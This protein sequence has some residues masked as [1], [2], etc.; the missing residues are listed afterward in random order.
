MT[1]IDPDKPRKAFQEGMAR[2][3]RE[4][5]D[6]KENAQNI[7]LTL[8]NIIRAAR[9]V[10]AKDDDISLLE[11][12]RRVAQET[13]DLLKCS[14]EFDDDP[15]QV[16]LKKRLVVHKAAL[17]GAATYAM[18][19]VEGMLVDPSSE[20]LL[21]ASAKQLA[22]AVNR[23]ASAANSAAETS[24]SSRIQEL[25]VKTV[26]LGRSIPIKTQELAAVS[27]SKAA[28]AELGSRSI[29]ASRK[30]IELCAAEEVP[31]EDMRR[32]ERAV[33]AV[34]ASS[35]QLMDAT[36]A[37]KSRAKQ[38]HENLAE[39]LR[40]VGENADAIL[41][42]T[43][44]KTALEQHSSS[45]ADNLA[46]LIAA[47]KNLAK[48]DAETISLLQAAKGVS[49][50]VESLLATTRDAADDTK[51]MGLAREMLKT[52]QS[53]S[54]AVKH[55]LEQEDTTTLPY[56]VTR[57]EARKAAAATAELCSKAREVLPQVEKSRQKELITVTAEAEL[58]CQKMVKAIAVAE[59][60][61]SEV[62]VQEKMAKAVKGYTKT[63]QQ[64]TN[65]SRSCVPA[66]EKTAGKT[67]LNQAVEHT[68]ETVRGLV[69][70]LQAIPDEGAQAFLAVEKSLEKE[71]VKVD[72]AMLN[73][74]VGNLVQNVPRMQAVESLQIALVDLQR[75]MDVMRK[76]ETSALVQTARD[77]VKTFGA[78]V[79]TS[80]EVA[81][82]T[83]D[84]AEKQAVLQK[85]RAMI[86]QVADLLSAA[87]SEVRGV[88]QE[89]DI[90]FLDAAR[91]VSRSLRQLVGTDE[92]EAVRLANRRFLPDINALLKAAKAA[93][94]G[95]SEEANMSLLSAAKTVSA[96][97]KDLMA[98]CREEDLPMNLVSDVKALL[99]S[100]EMQLGEKGT[101]RAQGESTAQAVGAVKD[102]VTDLLEA[103]TNFEEGPEDCDAAA[104]A[105]EKA[106]KGVKKPPAKA[107]KASL[108]TLVTRAEEMAMAANRSVEAASKVPKVAR[109]HPADLAPFV[110]QLVPAAQAV[111]AACN[112]MSEVLPDSAAAGQV[113]ES[114]RF[115]VDCLAQIASSSKTAKCD[116]GADSKMNLAI[117]DLRRYVRELVALTE[118]ATPGLQLLDDA[119][120]SAGEAARFGVDVKAEDAVGGFT[121]L[122]AASDVLGDS[123][124]SILAIASEDPAALGTAAQEA[125]EAAIAVVSAAQNYDAATRAVAVVQRCSYFAQKMRSAPTG[126]E[127]KELAK[128]LNHLVP[129]LVLAMK[130]VS[131]AE[132]STEV[133][134]AIK[135]AYADVKPA[136][137]DLIEA[138]K[139]AAKRENGIALAA[140]AADHMVDVLRAMVT[141]SPD[142]RKADD[143]ISSAKNVAAQTKNAIA[144]SMGVAKRPTDGFVKGQ[145][146]MAGQDVDEAR[147]DLL[148]TARSMA[149]GRA[150][151]EEARKRVAK[152]VGEMETASIAAEIG[153]L[154]V[155]TG[156]TRTQAQESLLA[157]A[158]DMNKNLAGLLESARQKDMREVGAKARPVADTIDLTAATSRELAGTT[159]DAAF[160]VI[161]LTSAKEVGQAALAFLDASLELSEEPNSKTAQKAVLEARSAANDNVARLREALQTSAEGLAHCE[162]AAATIRARKDILNTETGET[163]E[164]LS[165]SAAQAGV[166]AA[167][168]AVGKAVQKVQR[169][170]RGNAPE[171]G[172][173][174]L[175]LSS[176]VE[177][178]VRAVSA[179]SESV[180]EADL[181]QR[182]VADAARTCDETARLCDVARAIASDP[183]ENHVT[184]LSLAFKSCTD[185]LGGAV[186][187]IRDAAVGDKECR[188]TAVTI[189]KLQAEID[190][191]VIFAEMSHFQFGEGAELS[192]LTAVFE[193][194]AK[195]VL[196]KA[197]S[198]VVAVASQ[199]ELAAAAKALRASLEQLVHDGKSVASAI[200]DFVEFAIQ[201]QVF[202][203]TK[204]A[205]L[206]AQAVVMA[207][208]QNRDADE[209]AGLT[210]T[211]GQ[212]LVALVKQVKEASGAASQTQTAIAKAREV[213]VS[214]RD[215]FDALRP[216]KVEVKDVSD[217]LRAVSQAASQ[218][219]AAAGKN[220]AKELLSSLDE[221][222]EAVADFLKKAKGAEKLAGKE[223]TGIPEASVALVDAVLE[224]LDLVGQR[225]KDDWEAAEQ[226]AGFSDT[227]GDRVADVVSALKKLP[228]QNKLELEDS[229]LGEEVV[230]ALKVAVKAVA[231]ETAKLRTPEGAKK[232]D[233]GPLLV[234]ATSAII[235]ATSGMLKASQATQ[236]ELLARART[237]ARLNVFQRD[238]AWA[239]GLLTTVDEVV[240]FN[241]FLVSVTNRAASA[242][243]SSIS[244]AIE[245][246]SK[247]ARNVSGGSS[248]LVAGSKA[249]SDSSSGAQQRLTSAGQA[250]AA[251]TQALIDAGKHAAEIVRQNST[252]ADK[253]PYD[254][255][256]RTEQGELKAQLEIARL[257]RE[258]ERGK[259]AAKVKAE[260]ADSWQERNTGR[261]GAPSEIDKKMAARKNQKQ[262]EDSNEKLRADVAKAKAAA[263]TKIA[264]VESKQKEQK[265]RQVE[266]DDDVPDAPLPA[267]ID[268]HSD[269]DNAPALLPPVSDDE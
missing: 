88:A 70:A 181:R 52:A 32:I 86:P 96:S 12:A 20:Q 98:T 72:S 190:S 119:A 155:A 269:D 244:P 266:E 145:L 159:G 255:S 141:A 123:I 107:A 79:D 150:E 117:V 7:A 62:E 174:C 110:N 45:L 115:I 61:A 19:A 108:D 223:R 224:L 197:K 232:G 21:L 50:A 51:N 242:D 218:V 246:L 142:S 157:A 17:K 158:D 69:S 258:L 48:Q 187:A 189:S 34:Q 152:Q 201:K 144:N 9:E 184:E 214:A 172:E 8:A 154:N 237:N 127:A 245:E 204:G 124:K 171:I 33:A 71:S 138:A 10:A 135:A 112:S 250:V 16:S 23:M 78:V 43:G 24:Q 105:I 106:L 175:E 180:S 249:K 221:A 132:R 153:L 53:I 176:A 14:R 68:A 252:Q 238:P 36:N 226:I 179:A 183:A 160:Q 165:Y 219:I 241:S 212:L 66:I 198:L 130:D 260:L 113:V 203:G 90:T 116:S 80:I 55:T 97:L 57:H 240:R 191:A 251:A 18:G 253:E 199:S 35:T 4:L 267:P 211:L 94:E 213:I 40:R 83:S 134:N 31:E 82:A 136:Q 170:A 101:T 81:A 93:S 225:K 54:N 254:F 67:E 146:L 104:L 257:E 137:T 147:K 87:K 186:H 22:D 196:A 28:I 3:P 38:E 56:A 173:F 200:G 126:E 256:K 65:V 227:V 205:L 6:P 262:E 216:T 60:K 206:G 95:D 121:G 41:D 164:I 118:K 25:A 231:G 131:Q 140:D 259:T 166:I 91:N 133:K 194:S 207:T 168:R 243:I 188:D 15:T 229:S 125:A 233:V 148:S 44:D 122:Q 129:A 263:K 230:D 185:A 193:K 73:A 163:E 236:E 195:A 239:K 139:A 192:D 111:V 109:A 265:K 13:E 222:T 63:V 84:A 264:K 59:T 220:S 217:A 30:L 75:S 169:G 49:A 39:A 77:L 46:A 177:P 64:L 76:A 247:A 210:R 151:L 202:V 178:F 99:T 5:E 114:V 26:Q 209:L 261:K 92:A 268:D 161:S 143:L 228:G 74:A 128:A 27:S 58:A 1:A 29:T 248:K 37:S 11:A 100:V 234:S 156:K 102:S 120:R 2:L 85:A 208:S 103:A 149:T 162:T 215:G 167:A 47:G 182:L 89:D 235:T 42:S